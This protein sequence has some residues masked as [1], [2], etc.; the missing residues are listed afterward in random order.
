MLHFFPFCHRKGKRCKL[1]S[2]SNKWFGNLKKDVIDKRRINSVKYHYLSLRLMWNLF[3]C[4]KFENKC[5]N[6]H[7]VQVKLW[8]VETCTTDLASYL[9]NQW[10]FCQL[11]LKWLSW[12]RAQDKNK[13]H[14]CFLSYSYSIMRFKE[15]PVPDS[16][17]QR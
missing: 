5:K 13:H 17:I 2:F 16:W 6:K 11:T 12:A 10:Q 7:E 14:C 1:F 4:E 9:L 8:K 15:N 3:T